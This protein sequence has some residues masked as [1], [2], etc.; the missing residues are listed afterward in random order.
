VIVVN[1]EDAELRAGIAV[2]GEEDAVGG[3]GLDVR[4]GLDATAIRLGHQ[5]E[6][7]GLAVSDEAARV[8]AVA[9]NL[10]EQFGQTDKRGEDEHR[11]GYGEHRE[12]RATFVASEV[13]E[14]EGEVLHGA[15]RSVAPR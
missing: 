2:A 13:A 9:Q 12:N 15:V 8:G 10:V 5:V 6:H 7:A 3:D 14:H 1:G 4:H 11:E